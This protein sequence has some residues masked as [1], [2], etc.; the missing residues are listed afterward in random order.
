MSNTV[1]NHTS[2]F[3]RSLYFNRTDNQM[4]CMAA[5]MNLFTHK[6]KKKTV[7]GKCLVQY[8]SPV[9]YIIK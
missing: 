9:I 5:F 8:G 2:L 3:T 7:I 6:F 4:H 1:G